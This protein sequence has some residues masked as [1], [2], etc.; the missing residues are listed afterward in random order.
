MRQ[1]TLF[2]ESGNNLRGEVLVGQIAR[3][4]VPD[5]HRF[6]LDFVFVRAFFVAVLPLVPGHAAFFV[7]FFV[8]AIVESLWATRAALQE[9]VLRENASPAIHAENNDWFVVVGDRL[10]LLEHFCPIVL[11]EHAEDVG[12][13]HHRELASIEA[14]RPPRL[15]FDVLVGV[16]EPED[17]I[18]WLQRHRGALP[19]LQQRAG[20]D[21]HDDSLVLTPDRDLGDADP[22]ARNLRSQLR[23]LDEDAIV[24]R[25]QGFARRAAEC[26]RTTCAL[27]ISPVGRV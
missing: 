16:L 19:V 23:P 3:E 14:G 18:A 24:Q 11:L 7:D 9:K 12:L 2:V 22:L 10:T 5:D 21:R 27:R 26:T 8:V 1:Q 13:A 4:S 20:A 15:R 25:P 6:A 17:V